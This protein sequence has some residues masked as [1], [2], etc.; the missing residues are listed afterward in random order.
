MTKHVYNYDMIGSAKS[1]VS[2]HPQQDALVFAP[3]ADEWTVSTIA[4]CW[5]FV[6]DQITDPPAYINEANLS[7][8]EY[9]SLFPERMRKHPDR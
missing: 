9:R 5:L 8:A 1:G 2:L 7:L 6:A 3:D 4:D